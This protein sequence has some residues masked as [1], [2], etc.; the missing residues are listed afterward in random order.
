L[1]KERNFWMPV[2]NQS[3]KVIDKCQYWNPSSAMWCPNIL[4][5]IKVIER[6]HLSLIS[7]DVHSH[8]ASFYGKVHN[9]CE[10]NF[11]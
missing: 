5:Y 4:T 9:I 7:D 3:E 11:V 8:F 6:M 1:F 10:H 2:Y